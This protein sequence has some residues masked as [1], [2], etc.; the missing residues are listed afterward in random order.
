VDKSK[1]LKLAREIAARS[2]P[3]FVDIPREK[4]KPR[5]NIDQIVAEKAAMG[6][7]WEEQHGDSCLEAEQKRLLKLW[8]EGESK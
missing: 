3:V 5:L 6:K 7:R 8:N 1:H 2:K 4:R